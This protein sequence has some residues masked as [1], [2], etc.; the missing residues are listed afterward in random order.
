MEEC[1]AHSRKTNA[2]ETTWPD[3]THKGEGDDLE[4]HVLLAGG[5]DPGP[6]LMG[7]TSLMLL[8]WLAEE[9]QSVEDF[10]EVLQK[11]SIW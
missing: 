8:T 5:E 6:M 10:D 7:S 9:C 4:S 11:C 1:T 3:P 2:A